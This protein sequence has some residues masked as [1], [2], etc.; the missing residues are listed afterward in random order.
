MYTDGAA[1]APAGAEDDGGQGFPRSRFAR[2]YRSRGFTV[3][4]L[5]GELDLAALVEAGPALDS[6]TAGDRPHVVLDLRPTEFLDCSGVRLLIRAR[7]RVAERAGTL[8][9]VC[10]D[11]GQ[12]WQILHRCGLLG[13]LGPVPTVQEA[14]A[15]E[16]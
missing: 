9:L 5:S 3:L 4:E 13:L 15:R 7:N 14:L 16:V 8:R 11:D 2:G 10:D 1:E 6:V 12:P